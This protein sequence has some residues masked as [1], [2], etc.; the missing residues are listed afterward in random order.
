MEDISI[1][2]WIAIG[3][4]VVIWIWTR[5]IK[6][7]VKE[8]EV[9]IKEAMSKIVF[10]RTE[11]HN[12]IIFAYNAFNDEFVCQGKDM[13]DLNAQFGKRYPDRRGIIVEPDKEKSA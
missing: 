2:W 12:N 3:F 6:R 5:Q 7:E 4:F 9:Q 8:L 13:D 11:T 1:F 10:M